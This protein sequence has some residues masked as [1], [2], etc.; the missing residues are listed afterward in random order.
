MSGSI[1]HVLEVQ[2]KDVVDEPDAGFERRRGIQMMSG[3]WPDTPLWVTHN[4]SALS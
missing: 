4:G 1:I 3:V 2:L